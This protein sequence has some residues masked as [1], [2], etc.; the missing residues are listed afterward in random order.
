M[1]FVNSD[2]SSYFESF[3][4]S[5]EKCIN[6]KIPELQDIKVCLV[7]KESKELD[8]IFS[9]NNPLLDESWYKTTPFGIKVDDMVIYHV[10]DYGVDFDKNEMHALM[11]H[12]IGHIL[13]RVQKLSKSDLEEECYADDVAVNMV[14][15]QCL[16]AAFEKMI[17][18]ACDWEIKDEITYR[19]NRLLGKCM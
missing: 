3:I 15:A 14:G 11:F 2:K 8:L 1:K 16:V 12:E 7:E 5:F 17:C 10:L 6:E 13:F 18:K 9:D 4:N 19:K